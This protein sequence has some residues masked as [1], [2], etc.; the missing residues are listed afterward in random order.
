MKNLILRTLTGIAFLVIMIGGILW[1]KYSYA[2]LM[3]AI[4]V[5]SMIEFL[6]LT[7]GSSYK[8]SKFLT[9]L[10]GIILFLLTSAYRAFDIPG[11]LIMLAVLP[12]AIVMIDSLYVKDKTEYGKFA[13]MYTSILYIAIP[14]AMT[15][16]AAFSHG[17]YLGLKAFLD[18]N[19]AGLPLLSFFIL[20]WTLDTGSYVFGMLLGQ[21]FGKKLAPAISPHKSWVGFIG[22]MVCS[23]AV[24]I[25]LAHFGLLPLSW[26]VA[27]LLGVV[28]SIAG[29]YGDL[30]ESQWKRY[31]AVKDS[32]NTIP[33]HGGLLDRFDST[34]FTM[35]AAIIF[36]EIVNLL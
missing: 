6:R 19:P 26:W 23:I 31:Y 36:M 29:V 2:V 20:T 35:P 15:N 4:M 30:L 3:L 10:S 33:G 16:F 17:E 27:A 14:I 32:G 12:V 21:R 5:G 28:T 18:G 8:F 7:S 24:A 34:L 22:G 1:C 11:K 25:L 9:I 13:N